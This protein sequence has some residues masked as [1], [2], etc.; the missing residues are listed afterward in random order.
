MPDAWSADV[1]APAVASTA[2]T[3]TG[4]GGVS[5]WLLVDLM[6][7]IAFGITLLGAGLGATPPRALEWPVVAFVYERRDALIFAGIG[8]ALGVFAVLALKGLSA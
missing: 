8:I 6:F 2:A 7:G 4:T 1:N 3:V 5:S